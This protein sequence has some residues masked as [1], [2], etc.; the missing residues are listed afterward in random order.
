MNRCPF[1]CHPERTRISYFTALTSATYVVLPKE[2]HTQLIEA[3]TLE[4]NPGEPRDLRFR[5]GRSHADSKAPILFPTING[6][7]KVVP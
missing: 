7:T 2:N 1:L 5:D 3:A 6:P 4:G